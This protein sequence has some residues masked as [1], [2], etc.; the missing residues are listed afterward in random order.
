MFLSHNSE[1]RRLPVGRS[2]V[3]VA[4]EAVFRAGDVVTDVAY[5]SARDDVPATG[6]YTARRVLAG[7]WP[8]RGSSAGLV[9]FSPTSLDPVFKILPEGGGRLG[10]S[11]E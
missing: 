10:P 4:E 6:Q 9:V 8:A 1:L 5:F 3:A 2:F 7:M 11:D